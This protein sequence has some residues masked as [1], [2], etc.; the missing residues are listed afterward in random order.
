MMLA[1]ERAEKQDRNES[2]RASPVHRHPA[3]IGHAWHDD[4]VFDG[5]D[6]GPPQLSVTES[7]QCL[8]CRGE[9]GEMESDTMVYELSCQHAFCADCIT[10]WFAS[11]DVSTCPHCRRRAAGLRTCER[12]TVETIRSKT[13]TAD[14]QPAQAFKPG[15]GAAAQAAAN[16][17]GTTPRGSGGAPAVAAAADGAAAGGT[18][19]D[20]AACADV[21]VSCKACAETTPKA[22][23]GQTS[24]SRQTEAGPAASAREPTSCFPQRRLFRDSNGVNGC[25]LTYSLN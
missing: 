5:I 6:D 3:R 12:A 15:R 24:G 19:D 23:L 25:T 4:F 1:A 16:N 2:L 7:D 17:V 10:Q 22:L 21:P 18:A 8:I 13:E 9:F 14:D 20:A 11:A